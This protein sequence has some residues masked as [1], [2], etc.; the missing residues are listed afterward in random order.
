MSTP[1]P[2]GFKA[3]SIHALVPVHSLWAQ[4]LQ[5]MPEEKGKGLLLT[6]N[7]AAIWQKRSKWYLD[8][9]LTKALLIYSCTQRALWKLKSCQ[10]SHFGTKNICA[11]QPVS[12]CSKHIFTVNRIVLY[13][14]DW[15]WMSSASWL[16]NIWQFSSLQT[17]KCQNRFLFSVW[18]CL[19]F[20]SIP[21]TIILKTFES[22]KIK[23]VLKT[24]SETFYLC[25][26]NKHVNKEVLGGCQTP[27][28]RGWEHSGV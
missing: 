11:K 5:M 25:D 10:L 16:A 17:L 4:W 18:A 12:K 15:L 13:F 21:L 24:H 9:P 1:P 27:W 6:S 7:K 2:N 19:F 20:F 14:G 23:R 22:T 26:F 28:G 3:K 8:R